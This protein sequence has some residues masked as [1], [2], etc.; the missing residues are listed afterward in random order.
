MRGDDARQQT[1]RRAGIA[2]VEHVGGLGETADATAVDAPVALAAAL[3]L[4]AERPQ[5]GG[6]AQHVLALEKAGD[7]RLADGQPAEDHGA[8]RDRF[9]P[10]YG[11]RA[12]QGVAARRP[13][14]PA[15]GVMCRALRI[16]HALFD[17]YRTPKP[18]RRT[19]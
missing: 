15:G 1:G 11:D 14:R 12:R 16:G 4:G 6:G 8:V 9:V 5:G 3:H 18:S 10:R 17:H 13:Q 19:T 2:H 7:P